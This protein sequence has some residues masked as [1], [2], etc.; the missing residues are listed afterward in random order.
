MTK[1]LIFLPHFSMVRDLGQI[2]FFLYVK[3]NSLNLAAFIL[4]KIS[5]LD[6]WKCVS[7]ERLAAVTKAPKSPWRCLTVFIIQQLSWIF[8]IS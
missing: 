8:H 6:M 5:F 2:I 4:L 3:V 1:P 7:E